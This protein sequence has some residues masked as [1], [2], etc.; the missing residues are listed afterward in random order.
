VIQVKSKKTGR[1]YQA[2]HFVNETTVMDGMERRGDKWYMPSVIQTD[3]VSSS[4]LRVPVGDWILTCSDYRF[5]IKPDA[6]V[7]EFRIL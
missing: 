5:S 1:I 2:F 7:D 3:K 4:D 6:F